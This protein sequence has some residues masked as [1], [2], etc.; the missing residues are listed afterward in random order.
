MVAISLAQSVRWL[1][2]ACP[3]AAVRTLMN[4]PAICRPRMPENMPFSSRS[5]PA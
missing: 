1:A 4:R 2:V 3:N 5:S